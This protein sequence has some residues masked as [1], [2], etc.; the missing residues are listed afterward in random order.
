MKH[1]LF[2][3]LLFSMCLPT[4]YSQ[5]PD[6]ALLNAQQLD[7]QKIKYKNGDPEVI[8]TVKDIIKSANTF[9]NVKPQSVT[10]KDFTPSSGS[11]NDYMSMGPIGGRIRPSQMV[12][13]TSVKTA[14]ATPR[15]KR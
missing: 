7:N 14:S 15:S 6:L 10:D 8:N 4:A 1:I 3:L 11:K 9:L 13:L 12:C 2:Y 5:M